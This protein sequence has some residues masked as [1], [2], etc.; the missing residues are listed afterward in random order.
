MKVQFYG[1]EQAKEDIYHGRATVSKKGEIASPVQIQWR[2][3]DN[4]DIR[5]PVQR[6]TYEFLKSY[7][8]ALYER[9][10]AHDKIDLL[11][12][13]VMT[14]SGQP[15]VI[16]P[17]IFSSEKNGMVLVHH[18]IVYAYLKYEG[19][20]YQVT[21]YVTIEHNQWNDRHHYELAAFGIGTT[22]EKTS[23]FMELLISESIRNSYYK[24]MFLSMQIIDDQVA[25]SAIDPSEF[26]SEELDDLFVPDN[27]LAELRKFVLC[28]KNYQTLG[29]NLRYLY[30]GEPGTGKT[31]A[32]RSM[33]HA[34]LGHATV[35]LIRGNI[36]FRIAFDFAAHFRPAILCFDDLDLM[37]GSRQSGF[38][39]ESLGAFLQELDGLQKNNVFVLATTNDKELVDQAA[40]RPGRFDM[41]LDFGRLE[42]KNY[43]KLVE[44]THPHP[45]VLALFDTELLDALRKKKVTGA[46]IVNLAKQLEIK[47]NLEPEA[48]LHAYVKDLFD[49][50]YRGFYKKPEEKEM[51]FGFN[52]H[53]E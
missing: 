39:P 12:L 37:V 25:I 26:Q 38:R 28:I 32:I 3:P 5:M 42:K 46:F 22:S 30:C 16:S 10:L 40:S 41:V 9:V 6:F 49:L 13:S 45:D 29:R 19:A 31:K 35:I 11:H 27:T 48:D 2:H 8:Y 15:A 17:R 51:V 44:S 14:S 43:M 18:D 23:R 4:T 33:I 20:E 47:R 36:D 50:S 21:V 1:V 24:N 7:L 34:C 52:G 53:D